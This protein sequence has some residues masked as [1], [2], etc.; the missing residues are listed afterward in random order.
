[1]E[2]GHLNDLL[3]ALDECGNISSLSM[4]KE[5]PLAC[6]DDG[7]P[8]GY[9]S[10]EDDEEKLNQAL[11]VLSQSG[12]SFEVLEAI[13]RAAVDSDP[14]SMLLYKKLVKTAQSRAISN[15]DLPQADGTLARSGSFSSSQVPET[16]VKRKAFI[17]RRTVPSRVKVCHVRRNLPKS[18]RMSRMSFR[19]PNFRAK[20]AKN[21]R[22]GIF[23]AMSFRRQVTFDLDVD[24]AVDLFEMAKRT[25]EQEVSKEDQLL[26]R[27]SAVGI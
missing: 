12:W 9:G 20:V 3:M 25:R 4:S 15:P 2:T 8:R 23:K 13:G 1:M 14:E 16:R 17:R 24:D 19:I 26:K 6:L 11:A 27:L 5:D 10:G 21:R 22:S 18:I 7:I